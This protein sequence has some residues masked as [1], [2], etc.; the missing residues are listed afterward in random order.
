MAKKKTE[1][2]TEQVAPSMQCINQY[3]RDLSFENNA[4]QKNLDNKIQPNIDIQVNLD[5]RKRDDNQFEVIQKLTITAKTKTDNIYLLE[6]EYA[7]IFIIQNVPKD[8]LHPF[9]MIECPRILF[10]FMR[11]LVRDITTEGGYPP[12]NVDNIDYLALYRAELQR[13]ANEETKN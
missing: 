2:I 11:R 5:V 3:I 13:R 8:Q 4:A 6:L 9:L 7:G 1:E 10:P 12:I